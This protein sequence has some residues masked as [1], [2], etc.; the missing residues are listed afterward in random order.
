MTSVKRPGQEKHE[1]DNILANSAENKGAFKPK[2]NKE[3][4][5]FSVFAF[6]KSADVFVEISKCLSASPE[7]D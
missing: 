2:T 7:E 3:G 6:Q 4:R 1:I 5:G